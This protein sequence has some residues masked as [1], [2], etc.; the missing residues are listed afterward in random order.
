MKH[1]Q[2]IGIAAAVLLIIASILPW[3]FHP[4]LN[5]TFN[6]F[7]SEGG[8]YGKPGKVFIVLTVLAIFFYIMPKVWAKRWN[9]LITALT[10]AYAIKSFILFS[11]CYRGICPEKKAGLWLML[12]CSVIMIVMAV[13]PDTSLSTSDKKESD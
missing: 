5:K 3:T 6:G 8:N 1:S 10:L 7:F 13:F 11:G 12:I 9:L 4:D 2:K